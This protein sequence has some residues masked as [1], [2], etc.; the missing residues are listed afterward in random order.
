MGRAGDE[1][2]ISFSVDQEP[3]KAFRR[4]AASIATFEAACSEGFRCSL[5]RAVCN[6]QR[7]DL[8]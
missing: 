4:A 7:L 8:T 3:E 5:F 1:D 6:L 2:P